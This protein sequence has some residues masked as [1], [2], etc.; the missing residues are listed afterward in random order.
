MERSVLDKG[1]RKTR[2]ERNKETGGDKICKSINFCVVKRKK[3][4]RKLTS[5]DRTSFGGEEGRG[6]SGGDGD[7]GGGKRRRRRRRRK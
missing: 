5:K 4:H 6:R 1:G 3:M 2:D 7:G